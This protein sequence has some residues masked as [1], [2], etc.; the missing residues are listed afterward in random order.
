[1]YDGV[2]VMK[3]IAIVNGRIFEP[4]RGGTYYKGTVVIEDGKILDIGRD[5][6]VPVPEEADIIDVEGKAVLPG[7]IDAHLHI[8]GF[9]TGDV[10]KEPLVTPIG[11]FY[12][13]AV[14]ELRSLVNAGFTSVGDAGG[15]VG[16]HLKYAVD[17]GSIVGPRIRAAGPSLSQTYISNY[18]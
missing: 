15:L 5:G 13:R 18:C 10:I 11:V 14:N 4:E 6:E 1:M 7:L 9:R 3:V 2:V 17:E 8:T 12:A 16:L